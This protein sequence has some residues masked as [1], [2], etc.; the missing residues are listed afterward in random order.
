MP[1][2]QNAIQ[3]TVGS[4][5]KELKAWLRGYRADRPEPINPHGYFTLPYT[6]PLPYHVLKCYQGQRASTSS[7]SI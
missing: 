6:Y 3:L 5:W 4:S 2:G 7:A 1:I